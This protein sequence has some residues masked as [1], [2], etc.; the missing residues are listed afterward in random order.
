MRWAGRVVHR[1]R[2]EIHTRVWWGNLKDKDSFEDVVVEG[3]TIF[4]KI[5]KK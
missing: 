1:G 2:T 3:M 4:K 5:C